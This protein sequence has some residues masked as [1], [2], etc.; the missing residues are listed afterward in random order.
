MAD[1]RYVATSDRVRVCRICEE[2][3]DKKCPAV[4]L[5]NCKIP[6]GC[7]RQDFHFHVKCFFD[8]ARS[9]KHEMR[10]RV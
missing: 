6:G 8:A 2:E 1:I 3:I 10:A 5:A 7:R 9:A 4:V